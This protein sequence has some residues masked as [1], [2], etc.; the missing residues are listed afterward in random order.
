[1]VA[2]AFN[3]STLDAGSGGT[4]SLSLA[5]SIECDLDSQ[6]YNRETLS[7]EKKLRGGWEGHTKTR[8]Y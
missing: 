4:L 6:G 3:H 1:M 2:H 7:P 8:F 5:L